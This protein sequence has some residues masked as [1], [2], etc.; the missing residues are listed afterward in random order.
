MATCTRRNH[1]PTF[2]VE[3]VLAII[4]VD[5]TLAEL[6]EQ[7]A[8]HPNQIQYWKKQLVGK[9]ENVFGA[10]VAAAASHE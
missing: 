5:C 1:S 2:K 10:G 9:P 8:A 3:A 6:V 7:F 4:P